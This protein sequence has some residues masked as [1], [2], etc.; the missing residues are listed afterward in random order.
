MSWTLASLSAAS[1]LRSSSTSCFC[2]LSFSLSQ[3]SL[4]SLVDF[5][6][7]IYG[8][9]T[10]YASGIGFE[11]TLVSDGP[12]SFLDKQSWPITGVEDEKRE[13]R[14]KARK[15]RNE[16]KG[17]RKETHLDLGETGVFGGFWGFFGCDMVVATV[18]SPIIQMSCLP[19]QPNCH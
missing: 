13:K 16:R 18:I 14:K 7:L 5:D 19:P 8:Q 10:Q 2:V 3:T 15:K 11:C 6:I 12:L 1:S 9:Y 17:S 4:H